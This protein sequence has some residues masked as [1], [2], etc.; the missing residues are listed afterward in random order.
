MKKIIVLF[1]AVILALNLFPIFAHA[2]T[3]QDAYITE[4]LLAQQTEY[5]EGDE[6]KDSTE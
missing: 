4:L 6:C 2:D 1:L 3:D 5:P